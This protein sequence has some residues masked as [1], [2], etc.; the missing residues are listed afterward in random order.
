MVVV[1]VGVM[2]VVVVSLLGAG[3][4]GWE[5]HVRNRFPGAGLGVCGR[6]RDIT[7]LA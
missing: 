5:R 2:V 6:R 3:S 7:H 1:V 4:H